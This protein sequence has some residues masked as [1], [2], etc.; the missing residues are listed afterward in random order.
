MEAKIEDLIGKTITSINGMKKDSSSIIFETLDNEKYL[1]EHD[2]ECC[3][4]VFI[5][6][7]CG[8]VDDLIGS[9]ILVAE[10]RISN[11]NPREK[12][13][14]EYGTFT[15]TFY[16]IATAKGYLDIKWYGCSNGCYSESVDFY[17]KNN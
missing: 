12:E 11:D 6:D 17:K 14:G 9:P 10:E 3:E 13:D 4:S 2:Q 15:W 5:D 1:M 8:D 7:V 16:H